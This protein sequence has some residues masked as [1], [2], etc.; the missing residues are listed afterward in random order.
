MQFSV[1]KAMISLK[2]DEVDQPF[3]C[4]VSLLDYQAA[5]D[6]S[7]PWSCQKILNQLDLTQQA[8]YAEDELHYNKGART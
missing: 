7:L 2:C 1:M 6:V 4:I 8:Q 5:E 3:L